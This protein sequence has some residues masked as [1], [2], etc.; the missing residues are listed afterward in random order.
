MVGRICGKELKFKNLRVL[1]VKKEFKFDSDFVCGNLRWF[2][3]KQGVILLTR[4][5]SDSFL[6]QLSDGGGGGTRVT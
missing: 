3:A 1:S 2:Y 5:N 4:S 6:V